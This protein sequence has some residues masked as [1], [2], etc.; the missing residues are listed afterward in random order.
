[1]VK[2][3]KTQV[4]L[5]F[6][7]ATLGFTPQPPATSAPAASRVLPGCRQAGCEGKVAAPASEA[8]GAALCSEW[9]RAH[10]VVVEETGEQGEGEGEEG[11][12]QEK[13]GRKGTFSYLP[14]PEQ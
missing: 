2:A 7:A 9:L 6:L 11:E 3:Y 10:G 12:K 4:P 1:M 13:R 5:S 14:A 8:E